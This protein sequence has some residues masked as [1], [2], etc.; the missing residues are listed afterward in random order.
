MYHAWTEGEAVAVSTGGQ[1]GG[2]L[3]DKWAALVAAIGQ[4]VGAAVIGWWW[5]GGGGVHAGGDVVGG[6][7]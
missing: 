6:V 3:R 5:W 2:G 7:A 1:Q 4:K